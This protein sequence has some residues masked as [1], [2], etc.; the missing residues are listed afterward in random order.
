MA[1][2]YYNIANWKMS[3]T[4]SD[5]KKYFKEYVY[6][7][8][9]NVNVV[10]CPSFTS[11]N[12]VSSIVSDNDISVGAQNV[13]E[14]SPGA[15]TGE[16][17]IEMIEDLKCKYCIVGHSERRQNLNETNEIIRKKLDGLLKTS[18]V[19][20]VCIG[21]TYEQRK[22]NK[23][24]PVLT[25]QLNSIFNE[26]NAFNK[27]IIIAYEPIWAIGTGLSA[28]IKTIE[29]T[30]KAIKNII[31]KYIL[32]NCNIYLLYGGSVNDNNAAEII[33]IKDVDGF[34]IGS[35]SLTPNKFIK[36]NEILEG[37]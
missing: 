16:I 8:Y 7:K 27:K 30:H 21:E 3:F 4:Q 20:I 34:L 10:F 22:K 11:I 37:E 13:S 26:L 1:K 19:P 28:D 24:I 15:Y 33:S 17:S 6:N 23:T 32:K 5:I 29:E 31:N 36:I 35:S 2:K 12:Y 18:I 14:Y 25:N 9:D